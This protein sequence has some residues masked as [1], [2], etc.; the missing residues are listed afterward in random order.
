MT[1][2]SI[3]Q[4]S[5]CCTYMTINCLQK[6]Q[7]VGFSIEY[8]KK[9]IALKF[10]LTFLKGKNIQLHKNVL[11]CIHY[12]PCKRPYD[13]LICNNPHYPIDPVMGRCISTDH[14]FAYKA[15]RIAVYAYPVIFMKLSI[16]TFLKSEWEF[17]FYPIFPLFST[18]T[19][20]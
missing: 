19:H 9:W 1:S 3:F 2:T 20:S 7:T 5:S 13:L 16:I 11:I 17:Q 4:Y 18:K 8:W 12:N 15:L 14:R 6:S 10:P